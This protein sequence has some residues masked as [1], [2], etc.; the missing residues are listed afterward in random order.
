MA[1]YLRT[2]FTR[3]KVGNG[4]I[5]KLFPSKTGGVTGCVRNWLLGYNFPTKE[6]YEKMQEFLKSDYLRR[7]YEDL[8]YTFNLPKGVTDVWP[9]NF[10]GG[11]NNG[12][13]TQKPLDL[14]YRIVE[15]SSLP[16]DLIL[17]PFCGSGTT[18]VAAKM[19]GRRY[20]GIDISEEYCKIARQ[21]LRAVDTGVP[22]K[23][24]RIG[25]MAMFG[26]K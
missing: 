7:E 15:T 19:L 16:G 25:Q 21:R 18:C 26:D 2:E 20:I 24:Q 22:V 23:E 12:H 14:I 6:Q 13:P 17:D 5:A 1:K 10:Y 9:I 4:Q 8:R 11:S 3:A